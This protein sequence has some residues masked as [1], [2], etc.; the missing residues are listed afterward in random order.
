MLCC[1]F[2]PSNDATKPTIF[3]IHGGGLIYGSRRD[4]PAA[5][6]KLFQQ[7]GYPVLAVD[8]YLAPE[9]HFPEILASLQQQLQFFL[10]HYQDM[11]LTSN[12]YILFGRSAGAFLAMQLI[13]DQAHPLAFIDFYGFPNLSGKIVLPSPTYQKYPNVPDKTVKRLIQ[14]HPLTTDDSDER[15]LLYVHARQTGHWQDL[16]SAQNSPDITKEEFSKFPPTYIRHATSDPDVPFM[17]A[18]KLK[19]QLPIATLTPV[20]VAAHDFDR[21]PNNA[22][23]AIYRDLL[24]WLNTTL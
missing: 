13:R 2:Y 9:S 14:P 22:N 20:N 6:L 4:L 5:Y 1:T 19:S 7:A 21:T 11:G 17:N 23:L 18:I 10:T 24:N 3:Y 8:Y 15:F 12:A 16:L